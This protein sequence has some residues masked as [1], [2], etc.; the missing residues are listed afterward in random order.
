VAPSSDY[1]IELLGDQ[2]DRAAFSCGVDA[3][4]R[5][6]HVQA[7]QDSRRR[8]ASCFVLVAPDGSLA[9]Y[10]TLSASGIALA[11]LPTD[12]TR[13]L[14]RYPLLPAALMGRLA[15]DRRR[16]GQ[17]LGELLLFDAFSRALRNDLASYAF[18]V[19][20][21]DDSAE[22]FYQRYN[23][24]RLSG[25]GRRLYVPLTEIAQLFT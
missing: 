10:Y 4:D 3:L 12:I 11:D 18:L 6:L 15:V 20:A 2:H 8:I 5:Y 16:R 22:A 9:G 24:R 17:R 23:F 25:P 21:K 7:G 14:P 1:R 13:K 19:D